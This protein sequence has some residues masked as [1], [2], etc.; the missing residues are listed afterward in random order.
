[1]LN[2]AFS[3]IDTRPSQLFNLLGIS[4]FG[5]SGSEVQPRR[6]WQLVRDGAGHEMDRTDLSL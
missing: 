1:M 4:C 3:G 2:T 6:H 5:N